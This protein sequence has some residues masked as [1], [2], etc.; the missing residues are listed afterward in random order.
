MVGHLADVETEERPTAPRELPPVLGA[1]RQ[2]SPP[3]H[4]IRAL[5]SVFAFHPPYWPA[6]QPPP[7]SL[8]SISVY[9]LFFLC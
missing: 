3:S 9:L 7:P 5:A 1:Q 6:K 4:A 2:V 8:V